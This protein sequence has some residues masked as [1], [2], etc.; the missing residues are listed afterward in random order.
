ME[1]PKE[2]LKKAA[3]RRRTPGEPL[4]STSGPTWAWIFIG[5]L[6][7]CLVAFFS[8]VRM[9]KAVSE[10]KPAE[11][12]Q[13]KQVY[14]L[15]MPP[16]YSE[17][18]KE[19]P[20]PKEAKVLLPESPEQKAEKE[21]LPVSPPP[22]KVPERIPRSSERAPAPA[23]ERKESPAPAKMRYTLQVAAFN[24]PD[25][26]RDLV[27]QLKKKGYPAYQASGNAAA[28]GALHRV[29]IGQFPTLQEAKQFALNFEKREKMKTLITSLTGH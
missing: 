3:A 29:R 25:E 12:N 28:R 23:P 6:V 9:G 4:R 22:K 19:E 17:P 2:N 27:N 13:A 18:R 20:A 7:L 5:V 24:N 26:A 8:G 21:P 14:E 10:L 16:F 15:P 1:A 11:K